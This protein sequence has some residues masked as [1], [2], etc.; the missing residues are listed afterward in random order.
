MMTGGIADGT[1]DEP[2]ILGASKWEIAL[3]EEFA[4]HVREEKDFLQAYRELAE[5]AP[6]F[7]GYILRLILEDEARHHQI[8]VEM[9]NSL[10]ADVTWEPISP[11]VPRVE[12][13]ILEDKDLDTVR[14]LLSKTEEFI[15]GEKEEITKLASLRKD[16]RSVS[17]VTLWPLLVEWIERDTAEHIKALELVRDHLKRVLRTRSG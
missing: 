10:Q 15:R 1:H 4:E 8:F 3:A 17:E 13:G 11:V 14:S 7:I 5:K 12:W 6:P 16:L 9:A 2:I